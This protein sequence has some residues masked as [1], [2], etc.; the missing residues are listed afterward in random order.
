MSPPSRLLQDAPRMTEHGCL[1]TGGA[2]FIGSHLVDALVERNWKV[3]VLDNLSAGT[4]ANLT[5]D[6][7]KDNPSVIIGD[8]TNRF[9][10]ENAL[11]GVQTV[12][13]FAANPEVRLDRNDSE[14][15]FRQNILATHV[16]LESM[17][18]SS[19]RKIVFAS[20]STVYGEPSRVP[21]PEDYGPLE[22]VSIYGGSKLAC[23]SLIAAYSHT[24]NVDAI[25]LRLANI[26]GPRSK[27][28]VA[29]DFIQKLNLNRDYLEVMGDGTQSKSYLYVADCI[30][31]ILQA[32]KAAKGGLEVFNVG[33]A[34][35]CDVLTIA[36]IVIEEM[37]LANV[38]IINRGGTIDGKGWVG[39]VKKMELDTS[40]LRSLDW[41]PTHDSS[42]SIR[43][44]A[45]SI[46]AQ[47][48]SVASR[49]ARL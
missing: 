1:V 47:E 4:L 14:N 48:V 28:G 40:R 10:V 39:D 26:V 38:K 8:C 20:S 49:A 9:D 44:A 30:I 6:E 13:H 36:Q 42:E 22:P 7:G 37:R 2:G 31:A 11:S 17:K 32:L 12:F 16:L 46:L 33:S 27:H 43:L 41:S 34:D 29:Y 23:E 25:I 5:F 18:N 45:K 21:T 24:F 15:C 3:I 35:R 19:A